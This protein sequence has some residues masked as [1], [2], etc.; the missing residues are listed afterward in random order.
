MGLAVK[1]IDGERKSVR[2]LEAD[3]TA[4]LHQ[5][6]QAKEADTLLVFESVRRLEQ[7]NKRLCFDLENSQAQC[8]ILIEENQLLRDEFT[9]S[10]NSTMETFNLKERE[11]ELENTSLNEQFESA[12]KELKLQA[13]RYKEL[14]MT[15]QDEVSNSK[16]KSEELGHLK[17]SIQKLRQQL[18]TLKDQQTQKESLE[19]ELERASRKMNDLSKESRE[20]LREYK[21]ME[22][23]YYLKRAEY[24]TVVEACKDEQRK[25]AGLAEEVK[26]LREKNR[27]LENC[28]RQAEEAESKE[29]FADFSTENFALQEL[30]LKQRISQLEEEVR[31]LGET[32]SVKLT[33]RVH[34]LE[35]DLNAEIASKNKLEEEIKELAVR[36]EELNKLYGNALEEVEKAR[37]NSSEYQRVRKDRDTL[38]LLV[39]NAQDIS[40]KY[41][42]LKSENEGIRKDHEAVVEQVKI[43]LK[44]KE[45]LEEQ[46]REKTGKNLELE[47]TI[48]RLEER[49]LAL[50]EEYNKS[51]DLIKNAMNTKNETST[52]A[53]QQEEIIKLLRAEVEQLKA[54]HGRKV[55]SLR[56]EMERERTAAKAAL[57]EL[58]EMSKQQELMFVS[59]MQEIEMLM[60][61][62]IAD[63][64]ISSSGKVSIKEL[65]DGK[66]DT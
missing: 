63:K 28:V 48:T 13:T 50:K 16:Q 8:K 15:L 33:A 65:M 47:K 26:T 52:L 54:E 12:K 25:S 31:V 19:R 29:N 62:M 5:Q 32:S 51:N 44:D 27:Y 24:K 61:K 30:R 10:A 64:K 42:E 23:E 36:Y 35:A 21:R 49:I 40:R 17:D 59:S 57:Q 53:K 18:E 66:L 60:T 55:A 9:K 3:I 11:L 46:V 37:V 14:E 56:N 39:V 2:E 20:L 6:L 45:L 38:L 4:T 41:E 34:E 58:S 7:E 43:H 22:S 1:Y